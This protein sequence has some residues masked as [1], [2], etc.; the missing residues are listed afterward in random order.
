MGAT[1]G[2]S[3]NVSIGAA[4]ASTF[5]ATFGSAEK[6]IT[7][8]GSTVRALDSK[9]SSVKGFRQ[10]EAETYAAE[11]AWRQ[12]DQELRAMTQH[13]A[14]LSS[15]SDKQARDFRALEKRTQSLKTT[16]ESSRAAT[17]RMGQELRDAGMDTATLTA[18]Q[19]KLEKQLQA[20][21]NR[22][23]AMANL[24]DSGI[25][26]AFGNVT[27]KMKSLATEGLIAGAGLGYFFKKN[28]VD[29]AS[30]FER[31]KTILETTEGS[32]AGAQKS[33]NWISDFAAKTPFE[34][35]EVTEAF[36]KLRAYGLDPTKGLLQTLGDTSAAMGKPVMQA[37]EAI[38]DAVTGENERLK[39]FGIKAKKAGKM[40]TYSYTDRAG[41]QRSKTVNG[42][43]RKLIESTLSAIWN[44]KYGGAMD[45]LSGTWAGM[46]SNLKDQW[47]RF[48]N[49]TMNAGLFDWM[50][51]KLGGLLD[52]LN[53]M[54]AN[55]ELQAWAETT[56]KKFV[57]FA[58]GAWKLGNGIA[59]ATVK[60]KDFVGGW[61]NLGVLLVAMKFAP[62][63]WNI[64]QLAWAIGGAA[65][66][67]MMLATGTA[68]VGAAFKALSLFLLTNP[69]G[70]ALT[71]MATAAFLLWKNWDQVKA[72]LLTIWQ[73][74]STAGVAAFEYLRLKVAEVID[75]LA[76]KVAWIFQTVDKIKAAA[77]SVGDS[78]GTAWKD[79]KTFVGLGPDAPAAAASTPSAAAVAVPSGGKTTVTQNTTVHA[80]VTVNGAQDPVAVGK[81]VSAA[82]AK[83][84]REARANKRGSMNDQT[85]W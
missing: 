58:E 22:M 6:E 21:S 80:P 38:A 7:K 77:N 36:V 39:E 71:L 68:T 27:S 69:I 4:F 31:F 37:V 85:G 11:T 49:N 70:I 19:K 72:G 59:D 67:L 1:A 46:V 56:G 79:A 3:V 23:K 24:A 73:Q 82:L 40:V 47:S 9:L 45:K 34:L 64:G 75:W 61:E 42:E 25:G 12:A 53:T 55:G 20:S 63:I 48:A 51:T 13:L 16:F 29:V 65:G 62:L 15:I 17:D 28:F 5:R 41:K 57:E 83:R 8:L 30:E 35:A 84:E 18:E 14:G 81:E 10:L 2:G 26:K 32:A 50:K 54:A 74:I 43:N 33:M 66:S 78:I 44:E 60:L 52:R 76:A